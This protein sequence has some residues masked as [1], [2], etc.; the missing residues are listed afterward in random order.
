M[1]C[2]WF[3]EF[4]WERTLTHAAALCPQIVAVRGPASG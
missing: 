2:L 1:E 4:G 3:D